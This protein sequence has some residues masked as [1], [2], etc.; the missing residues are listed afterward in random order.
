MSSLTSMAC[1]GCWTLP[2]PSPAGSAPVRPPGG[3]PRRAHT[4]PRLGPR[5]GCGGGEWVARGERA[6][7]ATV[8]DGAGLLRSRCEP[9]ERQPDPQF[10]AADV[11]SGERPATDSAADERLDGEGPEVAGVAALIRSTWQRR[12][13]FGSPRAFRNASQASYQSGRRDL[14][15][16]PLD[17]QNG[18]VGVFPGQ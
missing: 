1:A 3:A 5:F 18:G 12:N 7:A 2:N 17:P 15:P 10:A 13:S 11:E 14:N 9:G 6:P 4:Q 16:R 8:H